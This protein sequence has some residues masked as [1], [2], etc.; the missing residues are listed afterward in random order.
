MLT[1]GA[2]ATFFGGQNVISNLSSESKPLISIH[3]FSMSISIVSQMIFIYFKKRFFKKIIARTQTQRRSHDYQQ[4]LK[5]ILLS[6]F[7]NTYTA[8]RILVFTLSIG[9]YLALHYALIIKS[10][11]SD[12]VEDDIKVP[13]RVVGLSFLLLVLNALQFVS[14]PA[15]R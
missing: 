6:G 9:G 12:S 7:N 15:L 1:K 4:L 14:N 8:M 2:F 13:S 3:P 11:S 10:E 5:N